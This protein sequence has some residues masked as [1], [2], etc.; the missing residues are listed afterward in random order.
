MLEAGLATEAEARHRL[1]T[2]TK[3]PELVH[4][5]YV[6][7]PPD[8]RLGAWGGARRMVYRVSPKKGRLDDIPAAGYQS[9]SHYCRA[10]KCSDMGDEVSIAVDLD[11]PLPVPADEAAQREEM[12]LAATA[13]IDGT[14]SAIVEL[15]GDARRDALSRQYGPPSPRTLAEACWDVARRTIRCPISRR[16]SRVRRKRHGRDRAIAASTPCC[17]RRC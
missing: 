4:S 12:Y 3:R 11:G 2:E 9:L 15:A 13:M 8:S 6:P 10:G 14:D 16:G 7:L 1:K 17:L 5:A